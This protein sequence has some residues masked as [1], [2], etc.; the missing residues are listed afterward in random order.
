MDVTIGIPKRLG[1]LPLV[2]DVLRRTGI[3]DIIDRALPKH[4]RSK[5]STSEC[6]A[7]IMCAVYSGHHDLWRMSDRLAQFDMPTIMGRPDFD[8]SQF[9]EE[10]LAKALDQLFDKNLDMLMTTLAVHVIAAFHLNTEFMG[11]DT[12]S[13]VF[14]GSKDDDDI[15]GLHDG[16]QPFPPPPRITFGYSKDHRPDLKQ[17]MFGTL[18]STDG[19]VPLFGGALDG[20]YSD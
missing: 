2:V 15:T 8:L 19:G 4:P 10:R 12:T 17:I 9:T 3:L 5:V 7:V 11:F 14:F 6:V 1:Y 16:T 20:N 18:V 13:L